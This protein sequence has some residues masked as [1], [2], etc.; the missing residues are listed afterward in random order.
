MLDYDWIIIGSGFGGSVSALRLAQ[1]GYRVALIERG[2]RYTEASVPRSGWELKKTTWA[3]ER[4][5]KGIMRLVVHRHIATSAQTGLGGGS[6]VYGGV[7]YRAKRQFYA[8]PQWGSLGDWQAELAPHYT[9]AERMLGVSKVPFDSPKQQ[10]MRD[11]AEHFGVADT[12]T[13]APCG[14]FF[15]EPGKTVPDPYFGGAG[16]ARAGCTS[17]GGCFVGCRHNA[18]NTLVKNYLWFAEKRGAQVLA[19]RE[20]IDVRPLAGGTGDASPGYE[21]V[22]RRST[23]WL[24]KDRRVLRARRVIFSAGVL[25]TLKLLLECRR[26]G[27]LPHLSPRLGDAVRTNSET[28]VAVS[29]PGAPATRDYSVGPAISSSAYLDDHT[30]VEICRYPAGSSFMRVLA[31]PMTDGE[32]PLLRPLRLFATI[33]RRPLSLL[34]LLFNRRWAETT[35]I[36]LVMQSLDNRMR[37]RLGRGLLTLFRRGLQTARDPHAHPIPVYFPVAQRLGRRF[38]E[39]VG[40]IPQNAVNEVTMNIPTTAHIL[41]GCPIGASPATG[42]IDVRHQVFGHPGLYVCD[43]S[44][45]PANLGVNPSLTI[46]AMSERA[47]S[48]LPHKSDAARDTAPA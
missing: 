41:G 26:R 12:F 40:G 5:M 7:L 16:P 11:M 33:I 44:A 30:H 32:V 48:F 37:F 46:T 1:K 23:A 3:P 38:A 6:I 2:Q 24:R 13:R 18:K 21:V 27:S 25:G 45:I 47:M 43:G 35:V 19:E 8:D 28:L 29:E 10:L 20:V 36:F 39:K 14:V 42:V 22:T 4:G 31:V 9:E 15:G 34:R 17:C